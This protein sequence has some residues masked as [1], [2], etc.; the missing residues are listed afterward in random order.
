MPLHLLLLFPELPV[1][2]YICGKSRVGF[3]VQIL[4]NAAKDFA[5]PF[6]AHGHQSL[7]VCAEK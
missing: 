2:T 6:A 5:R 4:Q 7:T 3:V 1:L